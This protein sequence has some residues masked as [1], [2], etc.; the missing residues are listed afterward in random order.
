MI[1]WLSMAKKIKDTMNQLDLMN[2]NFWKK[3]YKYFSGTIK[4]I[5]VA[6]KKNIFLLIKIVINKKT[7]YWAK[8]V[9]N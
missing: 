3:L 4:N 6:Y 1:P 8:L 7:S 2:N 9:F 5:W